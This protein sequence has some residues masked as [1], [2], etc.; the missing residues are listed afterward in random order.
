[1]LYRV[2]GHEDGP[3]HRGEDADSETISVVADSCYC[4]DSDD[5]DS[6][7]LSIPVIYAKNGLC[8]S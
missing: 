2:G 5:K 1:M 8:D 4:S 3:T 6:A 7:F